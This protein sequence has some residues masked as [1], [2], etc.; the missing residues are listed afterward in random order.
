MSVRG[1]SENRFTYGGLTETHLQQPP[2]PSDYDHAWTSFTIVKG[3]NV[4][5][6]MVWHLY[7]AYAVCDWL[8]LPYIDCEGRAGGE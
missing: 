2:D 1:A 3:L 7:V 5:I 8:V 4:S 6:H